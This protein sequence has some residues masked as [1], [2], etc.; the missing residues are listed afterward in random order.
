[1]FPTTGS[2]RYGSE[3]WLREMLAHAG[4]S[5]TTVHLRTRL[6]ARIRV[7]HWDAFAPTTD[8]AMSFSF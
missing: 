1:M 3:H 8:S 5:P 7:G 4:V 2:S 6:I